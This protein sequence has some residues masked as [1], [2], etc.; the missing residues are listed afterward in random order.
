MEEKNAEAKSVQEVT[1][2]EDRKRHLGVPVSFT[3]YTLTSERI[4]R[5]T[6]FLA[7]HIEQIM[8]SRVQDIQFSMS[9]WQRL[10]RVGTVTVISGDKSLP[11]MKLE[12]IREPMYVK[13]IIHRSVEEYTRPDGN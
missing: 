6:G 2:W 5:K 3:G 7:G 8:Y 10:F 9:L 1:L 13:E 4:I 12:N 11:E